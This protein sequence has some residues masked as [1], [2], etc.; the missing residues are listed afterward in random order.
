MIYANL[1]SNYI[2]FTVIHDRFCWE[3]AEEI[4]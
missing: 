1:G 3:E 4:S 2:K